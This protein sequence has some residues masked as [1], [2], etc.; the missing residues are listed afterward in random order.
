MKT[1][2]EILVGIDIVGIYGQN[3]IS[4]NAI[5]S[6]SRKVTDDSL[7]VAIVG[8]KQNG[9]EFIDNAIEKG[10]KFIVHN[11]SE[12]IENLKEG[13]VYI[14]VNDSNEAL[15]I[16]ANNFY[17]NPSSRLKLVGVTGTN[18]K[19]TTA[20]CLFDLFKNLGYKTALIS[21]IE[22]KINE[23]VFETNLT[24]PDP[25]TIAS[26]LYDAVNKG[27]QYAFMECS[28]HAID[29]KRIAG[30]KF[31]GAIFTNLTHDHLDYHKNIENY[32]VTKKKLFDNLPS[33]SFAISNLDDEFGEFMLKDSR[34][35]KY[36]LTLKGKSIDI[37]NLFDCKILA[38][39]LNGS[40]LDINGEKINTRLVGK[41]NCYNI[42]GIYITSLL[43]GLNAQILIK[44]IEK[45][46]P[47]RGRFELMKSKS[48]KYA[49]VDYAH[50]PD[51]ILNILQT[52][53]EVKDK[54]SKIITVVG[55]GGDRDKT[56]RPEMGAIATDLSDF[57]IFTSDNP[58]TEDPEQIIKDI[59]DKLNTNNYKCITDRS[60]AIK[61]ACKIA[62]DKDIVV[63][64][65]KGHEDYQIIGST[66]NHF[67]DKEELEKYLN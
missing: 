29:Q 57:V 43:L 3:N 47:P 63:V 24:T 56:K 7:F 40:L 17:E 37:E 13:I 22:N 45:I 5:Y 36:F 64:A 48:G 54:D 67:S 26:F 59:I 15:G 39:S 42:S 4:I 12:K 50:T 33:D 51:A 35:T 6:D 66:K 28:S 27:C 60:V 38:Q 23:E 16:I 25:I 34:A 18:G 30:L 21:T 9:N 11:K 14:E 62:S 46:S 2:N 32:S 52:I 10:A 44:E 61:E 58:R 20:T 19:T 65:G 53:K 8:N 55:C 41:F 49:V 31:A 1:L